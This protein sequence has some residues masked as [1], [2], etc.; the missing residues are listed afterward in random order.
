MLEKK[1]YFRKKYV[2]LARLILVYIHKKSLARY[3]TL[4]CYFLSSAKNDNI[5]LKMQ[6]TNFSKCNQVQPLNSAAGNSHFVC[7]NTSKS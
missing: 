7:E 6:K 3:K 2:R 4:V 1:Y 5:R